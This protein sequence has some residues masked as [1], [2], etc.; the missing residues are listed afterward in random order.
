MAMI[1]V[2]M[3]DILDYVSNRDPSKKM[4]QVPLNIKNEQGEDLFDLVEEIDWDSATVFELGPLDQRTHH[5]LVDNAMKVSQGQGIQMNVN[6]TNYE[7]VRFGLR[8]WRN[9]LDKDGKPVKFLTDKVPVGSATYNAV[10]DQTMSALGHDLI[11]ELAARI[12]QLSQVS[13][14]QA[15]N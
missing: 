6:Q 13:V 3:D 1:A 4:I 7:V 12:K 9:F 2:S 11:K 10:N 8:G 15:K 14:E 5:R